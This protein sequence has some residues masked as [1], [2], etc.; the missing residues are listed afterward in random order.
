MFRHWYNLTVIALRK[1]I[2]KLLNHNETRKSTP[3][4][5]RTLYAYGHCFKTDAYQIHVLVNY[6]VI[7]KIA[8]IL[9]C[10]PNY[11]PYAFT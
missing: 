1:I 5:V 8:L 6:L 3:L 10:W 7:A 2:Y 11:I 4:N 9:K